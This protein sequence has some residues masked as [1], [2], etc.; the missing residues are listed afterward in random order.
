M[1]LKEQQNFINTRLGSLLGAVRLFGG[2]SP[3][4]PL[5][6]FMFL[7]YRCNPSC[8]F[9]FQSRDRRHKFPDL[10]IEDL[11]LIEENINRS[12]WRK[13]RIH[14]FGGEPTINSDFLEILGFLTEKGYR[15]SMTTN[16]VGLCD[17]AED[18][19]AVV[20]RIEINMSLNR[21]DFSE[22]L[23]A[24]E[25]FSESI[26]QGKTYINIACPINRDNQG[27]L[28]EIVEAFSNSP[29]SCITLQH[30]IFR[31][32]SDTGIDPSL[33]KQQIVELKS[34]DYE[35]PV[36]F[37]PDIRDVDIEDYYRDPEF[38]VDH[39]K[40][41]LPWFVLFIQPNGDVIVCEE[42]ETVVGNA[43]KNKLSGTWNSRKMR[44]FRNSIRKNGVSHPVCFRCCHR[45]Y[46]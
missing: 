7:T 18:I 32:G 29:A 22:Q 9:C 35:K 44:A 28:V 14:L 42:I 33:L 36:L 5:A 46:Y 21:M 39:D 19:A 38:P 15:L 4:P 11:K 34:K 45:Q 43:R 10:G 23:S 20:K 8:P 40:C 17:M 1:N 41:V 31:K 25:S 26:R 2:Y 16:G 27:K 12:F 13:P 6:V 37:F 30:S 24:L 3:V